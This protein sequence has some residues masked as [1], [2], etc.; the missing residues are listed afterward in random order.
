M[1]LKTAISCNVIIACFD[2]LEFEKKDV[3]RHFVGQGPIVRPWWWSFNFL[4]VNQLA[5]QIKLKE[6]WKSL[7]KNDYPI[8]LEPYNEGLKDCGH[9]L[10]QKQSRTFKDN[11]RL[12]KSKQSF[13]VDAARVWNAAPLSITMAKSISAAKSEITKF[14]KSL[15]I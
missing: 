5:A 6:V 10:R 2:I 4:S 11:C 7:N 1:V 13:N 9:S 3:K 15:P 14:A 12:Q 8:Q